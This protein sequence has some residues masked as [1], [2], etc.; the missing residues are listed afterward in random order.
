M[1]E[2]AWSRGASWVIL[3]GDDV[4]ID[5]P[6]HYRAIYRAFLQLSEDLG[7]PFGFGCPWLNDVTFPG[8][9]TFPVIG[10]EHKK[11]FGGLIP[12]HR[13]DSFCNQ[14]LDPYLQRLYLQFGA[15]PLLKDVELSNSRGGAAEDVRYK[16]IHAVGWRDWVLDDVDTIRRYVSH[17]SPKGARPKLLVD[18]VVPSYRLDLEFLERIC[19]LHVP[20]NWR[21][22]FIIIVDNP[23]LLVKKIEG[24]RGMIKSTYDHQTLTLASCQLE[25]FLSEKSISSTY[26]G[27][28]IRVRANLK[29]A[30][31]SASRNRG[32][33]ESAAEYVLFLD[34]DVIPESTLLEEYNKYLCMNAVDEETLLMGLVGMVKFPRHPNLPLKHAA[35]LMSYLTFMFEISSK[36][37]NQHLAWGVT[38]NLLVK[39]VPGLR[40]DTVYAKSG[41]GEDVDFCLRMMGGHLKAAP[42]AIVH[43]PFWDGSLLHLFSHFFHWAV[44]DS[45]L[46]NRFPTLVYHSYPNAA[47]TL[48][49]IVLPMAIIFSWSYLILALVT[50]LVVACDVTMDVADWKEFQNRCEVLEYRY[51]PWFYLRAHVLANLMVIVLE[52]G[53]L[54]G[55]LSRGQFV[56]VAKRFDWHCDRLPAIPRNFCRKE[57]LK[58]AS[59]I[60]IICFANFSRTN[61]N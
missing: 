48:L 38:A 26:S 10:K 32:L 29:N 23:V 22:T 18:V 42:N 3:L 37:V 55:H 41:G 2:V 47:E 25:K 13:C 35:V 33:D 45:A 46:F 6:F 44:G 24:I 28:N 56:N 1:A 52:V 11:I 14:D 17:H 16:R 27:N 49:I 5:C 36:A 50:I 20:E 4:V 58:F 15:S 8:F 31:A 39:R 30:G 12:R 19:S 60:S 61:Y 57:L 7:C 59:F 53:R 43:H 40:F 9:P 34:D 54:W 21:T 51:H